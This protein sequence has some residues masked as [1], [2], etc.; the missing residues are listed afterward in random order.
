MRMVPEQIAF[1]GGRSLLLGPGAHSTPHLWSVIA[2]LAPDVVVFGPCGFTP[3]RTIGELSVAAGFPRSTGFRRGGLTRLADA[4]I[5]CALSHATVGRR[6]AAPPRAQVRVL[7]I[8]AA[9]LTRR[10][11]D[12]ST[13]G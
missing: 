1:A 5:G 3:E 4:G 9:P 12:C 2:D 10:V 6:A 8:S 7:R 11:R 13:S